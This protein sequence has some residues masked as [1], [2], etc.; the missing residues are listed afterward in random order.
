VVKT[1]EPRVE[2]LEFNP[3]GAVLGVWPFCHNNN[4]WQVHFDTNM[5]IQE[6][7]TQAGYPVP[8]PHTVLQKNSAS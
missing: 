2:I 5:A 6:V 7:C 4:Y 3:A 8:T 1:P